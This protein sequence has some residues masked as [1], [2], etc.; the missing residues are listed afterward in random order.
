MRRLGGGL[1][2][3]ALAAGGRLWADDPV[4]PPKPMSLPPPLAAQAEGTERLLPIDL[5]YALR[6]AGAGNPTIAVA[7]A[8][9]REAYEAQ[10]LA[11]LQWVPNLWFGGNPQAPAFLPTFYHH[12]GLIQNSNGL[13]F[14]TDKNNFFLGAGASLAVSLA[15]AV[16]APRIARNVTAAL[17]ARSQAVVNDIELDVALAYLDLLRAYGAL[18]INA[19]AIR[20]AREVFRVAD[21]ATKRGLGKTAADAD[22]ARSE[23]EL[24]RT[25]R[26]TLQSDAATASARLAQLLLLDPAVDLVPGDQGVLPIELVPGNQSIDDLIAAGLMNRPELAESRAQVQAALERW[27]LER[28]R[29]LI[30]TLQGFY[31]GGTFVGG[32][33]ALDTAGGRQDFLAQVSWELKNMGLGNIHAA[34]QQRAGYDAARYHVVEV[35][36]QVGAE[37]AA[38]AKL[39]RLRERALANAQQAVRSGEEMWRVLYVAGLG[40]VGRP[41]A[42]IQ[43]DFLEPLLAEQE[44][45]RA[46]FEYLNQVIEY[47]RNQFRLYWAMGQPPE[48]GLP[49]SRPL[50]PETPVVPSPAGTAAERRPPG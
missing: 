19:D 1:A 42:A 31:A 32:N 22:R 35:E 46:R 33:P 34:R 9:V 24:L 40:I 25:Q 38:A 20:K 36:A 43:Y 26:F 45:T 21:S 39:V 13:V 12:D 44:L 17:A 50:P 6:L 37:V 30:P 14:F 47:N 49:D 18:S 41:G 23:L 2:I 3:G 7:R 29:P 4:P 8:R 48:C 27:R 10:R 16:Y 5:P 15:D 11:G 28:H